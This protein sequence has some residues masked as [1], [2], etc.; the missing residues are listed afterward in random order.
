MTEI[1]VR[2]GQGGAGTEAWPV[3][4]QQEVLDA[5]AALEN[6]SATITNLPANYPDAAAAVLLTA[7]RDAVQGTLDVNVVSGGGGPSTVALDGPTLA[8]LESIN[9]AVTGTVELGPIALAALEAI[10]ATISNFPVDY[11]DAAAALLLTTISDALAGTLTVEGT[12]DVG[13][14]PAEFPDGHPDPQTDALTDA[15]LRAAPVETSASEKYDL[16]SYNERLTASDTIT[17]STGKR[18]EVVWAQVIAKSGN[19]DDNLVTIGFD[20]AAN[21]IYTVYALGRSAVF[22]GDVDQPLDIVLENAQPVTVNIHYREI[23]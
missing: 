5:L 10:T 19:S 11:P 7:I 21:T 12:V 2:F 4:V 9:A 18:I 1:D 23:D 17:P 16:L 8:A 6:L 20:G 13:N 3:E 14:W 15:E 22:V